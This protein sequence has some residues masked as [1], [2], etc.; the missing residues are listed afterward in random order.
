MSQGSVSLMQRRAALHA[1]RLA[2][3][4]LTGVLWQ[5]A[6]EE[7]GSLLT[8]IDTMAALARGARVAV[9]AEAVSR[10]EVAS[11]QAGSTTA[12]VRQFAPSLAGEGCGLVARAV[13]RFTKPANAAVQAATYAG[14]VRVPAAVTVM[15]E[16]D[17]LSGLLV[18]GAEDAVLEG[19]L[20]LAARQGRRGV[21]QLRPA[22]LARYGRTEQMER[23]ADLARKHLELTNAFGIGGGLWRY[24][25]TADTESKAILEAGLDTLAAPRPGPH[26]EP[27]TRSVGHRRGLALIDL[28]RR[29]TSTRTSASPAAGMK[30]TLVVTMGLE[31]L[32]AQLQVRGMQRARGM[33]RDTEGAP[34]ARVSTV[35]AGPD[36]DDDVGST[37]GRSTA[38]GTGCGAGVVT[39]TVSSGDLLTP[40]A[41]RRLACDAQIIPAVLGLDG[42]VVDV[43]R[44]ARLV[45]VGLL[46][47]LW[48]RDGSCSFPGCATPAAWCDAHHVRH[49]ADGGRTTSSNLTLLCGRH[50]TVVHR[51]RLTAVVTA[52]GVEWNQVPGSYDRAHS[53]VPP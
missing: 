37:A 34:V 22:M 39:G 4:D 8:E 30:T 38:P 47:Q 23:E 51:D 33:Q 20:T 5:A 44:T 14:E 15:D 42:E 43:G 46:K 41:V 28:I 31:D 10:G 3:A 29:A 1:A 32:R 53:E 11:S 24:E 25:L 17:R 7:L 45:T 36:A 27:D 48:I 12:W 50:H 26:G 16:F 52:E 18:E 35:T 13:E 21:R 2:L 19:L 49:W 6:G 9:A 40:D